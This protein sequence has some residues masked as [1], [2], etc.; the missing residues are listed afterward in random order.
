MTR[1]Q[2]GERPVLDIRDLGFAYPGQPALATGWA[3]S[4]GAGVTLLHGDTGSGKST[5]LRV[6]AGT[7]A[8]RGQLS[9]DGV[10]LDQDPERYRRSV[11]FV[12]PATDAFD[13]LTV[14]AC[15]AALREGDAGF[16][17]ALWQRVVDGFA[18]APHLEKSMFMLSTGSKRKVWLAAA[19]ASSRPLLLLDEPTGGLDAASIRCL[20]RTLAEVSQ[21]RAVV[22]ASGERIDALPLAATLALPLR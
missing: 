14:S 16:D 19:L 22:V 17:A 4:I 12:D 2:A 21:G 11:F 5:L 6:L 8:A 9:L 18:L 20:W 7:L 10:R 1:E 15:T 3:A 13:P